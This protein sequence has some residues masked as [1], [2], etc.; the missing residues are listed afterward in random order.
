MSFL[1]VKNLNI[2]Y[3]TRKETIVAS[4]NVEFKLERGEI[5][6]IVGESG[7]GKST[8]ANAI[9]DLID[10]PGDKIERYAKQVEKSQLS[11]EK[12]EKFQQKRLEAGDI[13]QEQF[14][15]LIEQKRVAT[16][17][18][19]KRN[20]EKI[21]K[22][23][24]KNNEIIE[25]SSIRQVDKINELVELMKDNKKL[26]AEKDNQ[27]ASFMMAGGNTNITT[28]PSEQ[29]IVMDT[30]ITDSFHSQV[31]RQQFG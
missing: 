2:S 5:L 23:M 4:K 1:E 16:V 7:S 3:P 28:N 10:T 31:V 25:K 22:V 20:N 19:M 27:T 14:D 26:V 29:T 15:K 6:G 18:S 8:I 12:F 24:D 11:F 9:I 17:E 30:K 13:T 21:K